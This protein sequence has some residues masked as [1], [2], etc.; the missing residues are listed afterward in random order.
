MMKRRGQRRSPG[1][2]VG[3][4]AEIT[5]KESSLRKDINQRSRVPEK[6][7]DISKLSS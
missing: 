6:P 1:K 3:V 4:R 5:E 7:K 2:T